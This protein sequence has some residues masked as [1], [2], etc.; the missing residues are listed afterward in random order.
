[1]TKKEMLTLA[2][3]IMFVESEA[4]RDVANSLDESFCLACELILANKGKLVTLGIGK[5]GHIARKIAA[6]LS[7]TGTSSF[8]INAADASH[9]D[10]GM[11]SEN[12]I[13]LVI[14]YSGE[15]QEILNLLPSIKKMKIQL[16]SITGNQKSSL[17][18]ASDIHILVEVPKEACPLNLA[19]TASTTASLAV[20]DALAST[21]IECRNFSSEDFAV[22]HP[23]GSIGKRLLMRIADIMHTD[24][25]IPKIKPEGILSEGLIEMS[26]KG[27]GMIAVTDNEDKA[28]GIFTD[29]DLR[30]SLDNKV[31]IHETSMKEVM[32]KEFKFASPE[33]LAV[34]AMKLLKQHKITHL[35]VTN[36]NHTLLGVLNIHDLLQAGIVRP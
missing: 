34:D 8:H 13:I 27:L 6:T 20:G 18:K 5:S 14:S 4:I 11:I 21:L 3:E 9:G 17:A 33:M 26:S 7:S 24:K 28:L 1:M 30:R 19:P 16:L 15:T 31:D 10:L 32:S 2:R 12:D 35:L 36:K 23:S 25:K 22:S 29:G